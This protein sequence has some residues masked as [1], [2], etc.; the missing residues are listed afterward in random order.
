MSA[1]LL[2]HHCQTSREPRALGSDVTG[3]G[4]Q[5]SNAE[6]GDRG[7]A[8]ARDRRRHPREIAHG[9]VVVLSERSSGAKV[10]S[11]ERILPRRRP[12]PPFTL[13]GGAAAYGVV[14]LVGCARVEIR[15]EQTSWVVF[16]E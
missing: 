8:R 2:A 15:I 1:P 3:N 13:D 16:V 14:D 11:V 12:R 4:G 9:R 6:D 7:I 10:P 5:Q